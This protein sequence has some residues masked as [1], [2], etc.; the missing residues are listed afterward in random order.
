MPTYT[1]IMFWFGRSTAIQYGP[2]TMGGKVES[3]TFDKFIPAIFDTGTSMVLVPPQ[4]QQD[5][6]GR[7]LG[8]HRYVEIGGMYQISCTNKDQ[9]QSIFLNIEGYWLE[10]HPE[11]YIIEVQN[12]DALGCILGFQASNTP[13]WLLGDVFFRG[14][15]SIHDMHLNRIGFALSSDSKKIKIQP[16]INP[17]RTFED[18]VKDESW[19]YN[20]SMW[21]QLFTG[22]IEIPIILML[23]CCCTCSCV[24]C[25]CFFKVQ[26]LNDQLM[27]K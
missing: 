15:Y 5:F 23:C 26:G 25:L 9:F 18:A 21:W 7:V 17:Q 19:L 27:A 14:Y 1:D 2:K 22:W 24:T 4:I 8:G 13:Y 3:Y 20:A 11:D 10:I 6:F 16:A 12:G